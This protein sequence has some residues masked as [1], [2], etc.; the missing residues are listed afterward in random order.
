[1]AIDS[2]MFQYSSDGMVKYTEPPLGFGRH[3]FF[4][5]T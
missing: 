4:R 2:M 3:D 1:M 5:Y